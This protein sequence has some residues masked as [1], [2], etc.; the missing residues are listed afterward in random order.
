MEEGEGGVAIHTSGRG[1]RLEVL[2][3]TPTPPPQV[4]TLTRLPLPVIFITRGRLLVIRWRRRQR[5][6]VLL[7]RPLSTPKPGGSGAAPRLGDEEHGK[8]ITTA[9]TIAGVAA[10]RSTAIGVTVC[11]RTRASG[12]MWGLTVCL[13]TVMVVAVA[14][15]EK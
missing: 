12:E 7:L 2:A 5:R 15:G 8:G 14:V 3:S 4:P 13:V 1:C 9:R 10:N 6:Q 11:R